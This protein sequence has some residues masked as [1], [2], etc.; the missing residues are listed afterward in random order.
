MAKRSPKGG[1]S[2]SSQPTNGPYAW[3]NGPQPKSNGCAVA[4]LLLLGSGLAVLVGMAEVAKA[5]LS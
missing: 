2:G 1:T 4:A 5:V 3:G